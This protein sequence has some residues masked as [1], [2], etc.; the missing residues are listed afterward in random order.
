MTLQYQ[1]SMLQAALRWTTE[2]V[3][4]LKRLKETAA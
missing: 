3:A 2:A 4:Q 1:T